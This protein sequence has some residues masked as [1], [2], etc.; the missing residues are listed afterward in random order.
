M[1]NKAV[2]LAA[3]CVREMKESQ[4]LCEKWFEHYKASDFHQELRQNRR[5]TAEV[6]ETKYWE[7]LQ[8]VGV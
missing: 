6:M 8:G 4:R 7:F 5:W 2:I 1:A 3:L